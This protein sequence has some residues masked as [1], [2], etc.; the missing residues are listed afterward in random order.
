MS[1]VRVFATLRA[2]CRWSWPKWETE[3]HHDAALDSSLGSPIELELELWAKA[4]GGAGEK[5]G[6]STRYLEKTRKNI[7]EQLLL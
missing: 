3:L 1:P 7:G 5:T 4:S 2:V 6:T